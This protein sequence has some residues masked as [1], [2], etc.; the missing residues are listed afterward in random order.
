VWA[1]V[2]GTVADHVQHAAE[3]TVSPADFYGTGKLPDHPKF[4]PFLVKHRWW[5]G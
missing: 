4:G 2:G 3:F 1:S 5:N